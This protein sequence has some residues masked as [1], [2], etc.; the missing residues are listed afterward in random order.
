M[1]KTPTPR[2]SADLLDLKAAPPLPGPSLGVP[3][4]GE[5]A[6]TS[7]QDPTCHRCPKPEAR[8]EALVAS[9]FPIGRLGLRQGGCERAG[10]RRAPPAHR[11]HGWREE[12]LRPA[13]TVDKLRMG[14][15]SQGPGPEETE[16]EGVL[17]TIGIAGEIRPRRLCA[18]RLP[19]HQPSLTA[20]V[21]SP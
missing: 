13:L 15:G 9:A 17:F 5:I 16:E 3:E 19:S 8:V 6:L 1:T 20:L 21:F 12:S 4:R 2:V 14:V 7:N 18:H 11:T 10:G